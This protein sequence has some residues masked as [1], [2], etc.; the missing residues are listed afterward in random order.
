[1]IADLTMDAIVEQ[2]FYALAD[3]ETWR[4][5]VAERFATILNRQE[6]SA[7]IYP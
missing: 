6:P 3:W 2:R 4:P 1:M 5:L 7:P